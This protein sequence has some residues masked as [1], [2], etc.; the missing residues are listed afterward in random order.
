M[1]RC[2]EVTVY[3]MALILA[4]AC[5]GLSLIHSD[6]MDDEVAE[7]ETVEEAM[8][9]YYQPEHEPYDERAIKP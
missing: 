4:A 2:R 7:T 5:Y 1:G 9:E 8:R 3:F 6:D